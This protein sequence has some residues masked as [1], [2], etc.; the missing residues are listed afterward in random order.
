MPQQAAPV[1]DTRKSSALPPSTAA[2]PADKAESGDSPDDQLTVIRKRVSEV[3][4][5]FTVTDKRGHFVKDLTQSDFR[6]YDDNK[7]AESIRSFNRE[8]DLPLRVGLLIDASN[9]VRDR[10]KFEQESAIEFLNQI[11]RRTSDKAFVIGFDTTPEVT[12]DMTDDTNALSH[13]VRMLRPG[14]GTAMYDAIYY[15]ARDKLMQDKSTGATRRAIIL[16]SDGDDNQSRV[17]RE[18]AVEM[19]HRAEV[20]IYAISTYTSGA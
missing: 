5:V 4:V 15:A 14:G 18:D 20:I 11:I 8:T 6:V 3:N 2:K 16:L 17:S 9:S 10:F 19:A 7:P 13:G 12:Q 1:G